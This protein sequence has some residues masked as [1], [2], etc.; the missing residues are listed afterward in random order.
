M[1]FARIGRAHSRHAGW[2]GQDKGGDVLRHLKS[3]QQVDVY[4][5]AFG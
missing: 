3:R 4:R 2:M 1:S 5:L